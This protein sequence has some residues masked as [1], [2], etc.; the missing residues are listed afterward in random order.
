MFQ[1]NFSELIACDSGE[2][3]DEGEE[4]TEEA[5]RTIGVV[6]LKATLC[7]AIGTRRLGTVELSFD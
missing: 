6:D 7:L 4:E 5:Y 1:S 3:V 2:G